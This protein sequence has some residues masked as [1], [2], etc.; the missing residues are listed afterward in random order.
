MQRKLCEL[1]FTDNFFLEKH[2]NIC[3]FHYLVDV[4][5]KSA[6]QFFHDLA[7]CKVNMYLFHKAA[8]RAV[9][10]SRG[11]EGS[12]LHLIAVCGNVVLLQ[13]ASVESIDFTLFINFNAPLYYFHRRIQ[14]L[15]GL[16]DFSFCVMPY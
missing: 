10:Y 13:R 8:Q 15:D 11:T 5:S 1:F 3:C 16:F 7:F 9:H 2:V 14:I 6:G 4:I 12:R